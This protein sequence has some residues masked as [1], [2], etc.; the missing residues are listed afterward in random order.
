M[1]FTVIDYVRDIQECWRENQNQK[2][3]QLDNLYQMY[4]I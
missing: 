4:G 1:G 3:K 2:D